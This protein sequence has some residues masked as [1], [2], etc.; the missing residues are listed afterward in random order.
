MQTASGWSLLVREL[1]NRGHC[2]VCVIL[3]NDPDA[4]GIQYV[5]V[6][7]NAMADSEEGSIV[8]SH[9]ASGLFLPLAAAQRSYRNSFFWPRS[10][11]KS[12]RAFWRRRGKI[13]TCF[14]L[15]IG[16]DPHPSA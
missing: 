15:M 11:F 16:K 13:L 3:P 6:I 12:A 4:S 10:S 1:E 9:S 5:T 7:A 14:F 2:T 8:V